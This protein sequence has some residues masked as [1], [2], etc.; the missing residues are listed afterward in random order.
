M[1]TLL[2]GVSWDSETDNSL[3]SSSGT[4]SGLASLEYSTLCKDAAFAYSS[5]RL[6]YS[7]NATGR[8]ELFVVDRAAFEEELKTGDGLVSQGVILSDSYC[9]GSTCQASCNLKE[10]K[11][12]CLVFWNV[13]N[14]Q[15]P[16]NVSY[17][18][19][20]SG[21]H[22]DS[23]QLVWILSSVC[24][25]LVLLLF[26]FCIGCC[27]VSKRRQNEKNDASKEAKCPQQVPLLQQVVHPSQDFLCPM[28]PPPPPPPLPVMV[29]SSS[30]HSLH[31]AYFQV[32]M[33][34]MRFV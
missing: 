5:D 7:Y 34:S 19:H 25:A 10:V 8:V 13:D 26:G 3:R 15:K 21:G 18:Y 9:L 31:D 22:E 33:K 24:V 12:W 17:L 27:V 6:E 11:D 4:L 2:T 16:V 20:L 30:H 28:P 29:P 23:D 14:D 32:K 1:R